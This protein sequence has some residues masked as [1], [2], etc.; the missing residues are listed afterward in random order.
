MY[1]EYEDA[2]LEQFEL[3]QNKNALLKEL[4]AEKSTS[5]VKEIQEFKE[6]I[7]IMNKKKDK[8]RKDMLLY[9]KIAL[10]IKVY[11]GQYLNSQN[12]S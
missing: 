1:K 4:Q 12:T 5:K 11:L 8:I 2:N 7:A 3:I 6:K 9:N 10:E